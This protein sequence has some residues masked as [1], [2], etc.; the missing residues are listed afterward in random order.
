M[1]F[2]V[3]RR[4]ETKTKQKELNG[5]EISIVFDG[6]TSLGEVLVVIVRFLDSEW[7]MQQ[8]FIRFPWVERSLNR[9]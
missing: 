5:R 8:R 7:T 2:P 6:A 9:E 3:I 1:L 4:E